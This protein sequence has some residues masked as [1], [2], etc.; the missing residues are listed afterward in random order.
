MYQ[1]RDHDPWQYELHRT[2]IPMASFK[3]LRKIRNR[4]I[5][6][7]QINR[8]LVDSVRSLTFPKRAAL[9]WRYV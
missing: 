2:Y 1:F 7:G 3:V 5:E 9:N 6:Y 8:K 4:L